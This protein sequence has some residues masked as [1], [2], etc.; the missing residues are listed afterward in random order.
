METKVQIN[1]WDLIKLKYFCPTK[2]IT[3]KIKGL[4]TKWDKIFVNNIAGEGLISKL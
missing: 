4:S 1:K 2:G 3:N